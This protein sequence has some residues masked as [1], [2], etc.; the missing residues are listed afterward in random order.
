VRLR[1]RL[2]TRDQERRVQGELELLGRWQPIEF[3]FSESSGKVTGEV[4]LRP[5][6]WGI[7]PYKALLGAIRLQDRV[8]VRFELT[9]ALQTLA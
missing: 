5:S 7:E 3:P 8:L 1:A 4:E 6:R 2:L 9:P